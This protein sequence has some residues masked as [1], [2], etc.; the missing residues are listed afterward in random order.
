M[1]VRQLR[2]FDCAENKRSRTDELP[3]SFHLGACIANQ[4]E[5]FRKHRL[6]G[7][8]RQP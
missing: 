2:I 4:V 6:G 8:Q 5:N 3:G 1:Q 7:Q